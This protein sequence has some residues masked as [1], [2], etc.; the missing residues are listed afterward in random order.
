M[1]HRRSWMDHVNDLAVGLS[2]VLC[3]DKPLAPPLRL[4]EVSGLECPR[5]LGYLGYL[6]HALSPCSGFDRKGI[7]RHRDAEY[8]LVSIIG[9]IVGGKP[10][11]QDATVSH[12]R[13]HH[14][15]RLYAQMLFQDRIGDGYP[16]LG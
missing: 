3:L 15:P 10:L 9:K 16:R 8:G 12:Y 7:G 2:L 11:K 4:A 5:G 6:L 13:K 1:V 14:V